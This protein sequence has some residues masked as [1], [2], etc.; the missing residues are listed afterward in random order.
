MT[1]VYSED[2]AFTGRSAPS[3]CWNFLILGLHDVDPLDMKKFHCEK[4]ID[5]KIT[6]MRTFFLVFYR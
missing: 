4:I 6:A 3:F 2:S 1:F 5:D